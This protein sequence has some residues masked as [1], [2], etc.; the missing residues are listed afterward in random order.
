MGR[1]FRKPVLKNIPVIN[2]A[3]K[4]RDTPATS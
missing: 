1:S 3:L 2:S 4:E